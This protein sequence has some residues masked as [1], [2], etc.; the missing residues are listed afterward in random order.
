MLVN[1]GKLSRHRKQRRLILGF[2][3]N[4][5]TVET[6]K[7][8]RRGNDL[9]QNVITLPLASRVALCEDVRARADGCWGSSNRRQTSAVTNSALFISGIM[10]GDLITE[11]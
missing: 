7:N 3:R 9:P 10:E 8:T 4:D 2:S 6:G 11:D 5:S 1:L